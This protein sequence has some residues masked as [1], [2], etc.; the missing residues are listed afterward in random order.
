MLYYLTWGESSNGDKLSFQEH[1]DA[2]IIILHAM[3]C[4]AS[5]SW[6]IQHRPFLGRSRC[7]QW[8]VSKEG[9]DRARGG[10]MKRPEQGKVVP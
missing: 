2:H 10:D 1:I 8:K 4:Y 9:Q 7:T 3:L 6:G 5:T